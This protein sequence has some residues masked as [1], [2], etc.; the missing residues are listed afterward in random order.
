MSYLFLVTIG[1]VQEFIAAARRSRDLWFGSWLLSELSRTAASTIQAADPQATLI[2]PPS[3]LISGSDRT[4]AN[5]ANKILARVAAP[6]STLGSTVADAVKARLLALWNAEATQQRLKGPFDTEAADQQIVDL[7]ETLWVTVELPSDAAYKRA[8]RQIEALMAA[9]KATRD[10]RP[11]TWGRKVPKS[12]IDG[13]REAVIPEDAYPPPGSSPAAR[14]PYADALYRDYRAGPA[15]RLSGVDLLKRHGSSGASSFFPSTA[16]IAVRP[17]LERL[18]GRS[19]AA[20][21]WNAYLATI[22]QLAQ[23]RLREEHVNRDH[24]LLGPYDGGLL[25]ESRLRELFD[26]RAQREEASRAL[27]EFFHALNRVQA[28]VGATIPRPE[29]YYA[30]LLADGDR[31]GATIDGQESIERHLELS[32][33]M[34]RFA[35]QARTIVDDHSGALIYAGGDD[36]LAFVPLH[37]LLACAAELH[38]AFGQ[39][40]NPRGDQTTPFQDDEGRVPTLSV[41]VAICHQIEPL[42]DALALARDAE[43]AAKRVDGKDALAIT[44]SKRSGADITISGK[45]SILAAPSAQQTAPGGGG[46]QTGTPTSD[47]LDTELVAYVTMHR[48]DALPDGAAFQLRDL[49]ERLTPRRGQPTLPAPAALGEARRIIGRKQLRR[50]IASQLADQTRAQLFDALERTT[51]GLM[52]ADAD[53][54]EAERR[55]AALA[56]IRAL[57][58]QLIVAR[59]LAVAADHAYGPLDKEA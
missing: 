41:G 9:R 42:S 58:D 33:R 14:K 44:L 46:A 25:L 16:D 32:R 30:I 20:Q 43:R 36:V 55:R 5:V 21:E 6:P 23:G 3:E 48:I 28:E 27:A 40:I 31:M 57:A 7:I 38:S 54:L 51:L 10:F 35:T 53:D 56:A 34:G 19:K 1:P 59:E 22:E 2:F 37:T 11:V 8:R 13:Q 29:P 50:G 52:S 39:I 24:A 4:L 15:E 49:A 12:S 45:W 18:S 47:G 17:L 26:D